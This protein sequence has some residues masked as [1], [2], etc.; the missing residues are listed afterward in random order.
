MKKWLAVLMVVLSVAAHSATAQVPLRGEFEP[1]VRMPLAPEVT[2]PAPTPSPA[3]SGLPPVVDAP[4]QA[5]PSAPRDRAESHAGARNHSGPHP[6]RSGHWF[7]LGSIQS[8]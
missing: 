7:R 2:L 6:D 8:Q 3:P 1:P 4:G 5:E